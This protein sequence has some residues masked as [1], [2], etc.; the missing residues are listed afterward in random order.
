MEDIP[1]IALPPRLI[2][3]RHMKKIK[4]ISRV[5]TYNKDSLEILLVKNKGTSFWYAPGGEW[6]FDKESIAECGK[7]EV[8]EETGL[9]VNIVKLLYA[10]EFHG[11]EGDTEVVCLET[12]WLGSL[13]QE[14]GLNDNHVD[15]D[16]NGMVE[17]AKW[18]KKQDLKDLKVFPE[19]LKNTFWDNI[20]ILSESE[21]PFMGVS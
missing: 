3:N 20:K 16:P 9:H 11:N 4:P 14:Q 15:L 6:E 18:F 1:P 8:F 2:Y 17:E 5:I 13:S 7:R 10:Q 21:D 12:F 19:R